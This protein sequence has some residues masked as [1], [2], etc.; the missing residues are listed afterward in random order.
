[1]RIQEN[2]LLQLVQERGFSQYGILSTEGLQ[3]RT[4]V[5]EMCASDRCHLYGRS[6]KCPPACGSL[7]EIREEAK[8]FRKGIVLQMTGQMEDDYDIETMMET[9]VT[10]KKKVLA[11]VEEL[12]KQGYEVLPMS[13][14]GC[15]LC[16][17]CTYPD[18]PCRFPDK[19]YPSMEAYGL[20]V[21]DCCTMAGVKYYYGP[22]TITFSACI[23]F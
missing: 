4:E 8:R 16:K 11:L 14:G 21:S 7:E 18:A 22:K 5:R 23:L 10:L 17:E 9:E 12:K 3:F 15:T 20:V 6:W 19:A 13:A 2:E 1:M